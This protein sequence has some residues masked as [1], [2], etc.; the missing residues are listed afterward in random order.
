MEKHSFFTT[1]KEI[2]QLK[3]F[4][5]SAT[6]V[7]V[8][9]LIA[10]AVIIISSFIVSK[11]IRKTTRHYLEKKGV[12]DPGTI[13][14]TN[15]LIHL[16]IVALG[17]GLAIRTIGIN[18][19]AL[20]AAGALFAIGIGFAMQNIAQNFVSGL[21]LMVERTVKP[22]DVLLIE[23]QMV[24][25]ISMG[26]RAIVA[27]TFD[28]ED[29][30]IPNS[31]LVQ[32]T[33]KNFTLRDQIYRI[34]TIVGVIYG[35][36]MRLVRKTLQECANRLPERSNAKKPVILMTEFGDSSVNFDVSVWVDDP[37]MTRLAKSKL[38]EAIWWALKDA[39]IVIAF[40]QVDVHFDAPVMDSLQTLRRASVRS[41]EPPGE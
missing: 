33:V 3:L 38:N 25:V 22:G 9:T 40:P 18:I 29:L 34:R 35:S 8:A 14:V 26:M 19:A 13:S 36:D 1:V 11:A 21:I 37:W 2:L 7:T 27:R 20:F 16:M 6:E 41:P 32:S 30:I 4:T 28:D 12:V 17:L 10:C 5:I 31:V 39:G 15:R 23:G 24:K